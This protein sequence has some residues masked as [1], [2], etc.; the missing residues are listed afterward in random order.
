MSELDE[1]EASIKK[2]LADIAASRQL[3]E[4]VLVHGP[5]VLS[6]IAAARELDERRWVPVTE[7]EPDSTGF[8]LCFHM[9]HGVDVLPWSTRSGWGRTEFWDHEI[10]THW[11]PLPK[12]PTNGR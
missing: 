3:T 6:L 10:P 2:Q 12:E 8:Y 5:T 7:R 1:L 11:M 9:A 4:S